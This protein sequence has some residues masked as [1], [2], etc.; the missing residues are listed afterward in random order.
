MEA[1]QIAD[2]ESTL[3]NLRYPTPT[4]PN[5]TTTAMIRTLTFPLRRDPA[6]SRHIGYYATQQHLAYNH[7]V[8]VLNREPELP[9]RSG[10]IH[11]DALNKRITAWRQAHRQKADAPY[12][13]HQEGSEQ[14]WEANQ[15][16]QEA[17]AARL[18]RIAQAEARA[19]H[20]STATPAHI[21]APWLIAPANTDASASPSPTG[22]YS[23]SATT[24]RP[25]PAASALSPSRFAPTGT[26]N[27][28]T[29]A[30]YNWSP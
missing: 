24:D 25:S 9:K 10:R 26:S 27:S 14:A 6:N 2:H 15:R 18:E 16:L 4:A 29:S 13:I 1:Q 23:K 5:R 19:K 22:G 11:P 7:A 12:Y 30:P 3:L 20:P 28:W 8:D 21:A 17:H